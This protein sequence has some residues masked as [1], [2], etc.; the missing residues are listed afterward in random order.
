MNKKCIYCKNNITRGKNHSLEHIFPESFGCPKELTINCVCRS[1]NN[2]LGGTIDRYLSFDSL[3][4][5][6]RWRTRGSEYTKDLEHYKRLVRTIPYEEQSGDFQGVKIIIDLK[7]PGKYTLPRQIGFLKKNRKYEYITIDE[8]KHVNIQ[9]RLKDLSLDKFK[10]HYPS[11]EERESTI[12]QLIDL[13]V[14]SKSFKTESEEFGFP[15]KKNYGGKIPIQMVATIDSEIYRAV[16]KISF[17]Y[18]AKVQGYEYTLNKKF[19]DI[20]EFIRYSKNPKRMKFVT[21]N[22]SPILYQETSKIKL[23]DGFIVV[24]ERV[25]NNIV[26]RVSIF[27]DMIY[28]VNLTINSEK[29]IYPF[30]KAGI[31]YD[32]KRGNIIKVMGV[33]KFL[34]I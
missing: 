28:Q 19:N 34:L 5:D 1:C 6:K 13:K 15:N 30:P 25:G 26:S 33:S 22:A 11:K 14:I 7:N 29:I 20:R 9:H 10:I 32:Y 31:A 24:I 18:L 4:G 12:N 8:L 3:E 2:K 21:P 17:N 27:N 16:A 23:F